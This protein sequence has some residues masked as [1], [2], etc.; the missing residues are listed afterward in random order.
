MRDITNRIINRIP[1]FYTRNDQ[2]VLIGLIE[3]IAPEL[4]RINTLVDAVSDMV[5]IDKV[6][7]QDLYERFGSLFNLS[8][9][10]YEDNDMYR[11]RIKAVV[12]SKYGGTKE[13]IQNTVATYVG[14]TNTE[15]IKKYIKIVGGWDYEGDDI[16]HNNII[17]NE[18]ND[19]NIGR[20][21]GYFIVSIDPKA[22]YGKTYVT[23]AK[24]VEIVNNVKAAGVCV[25]MNMVFTTERENAIISI[26]ED[27]IDKIIKNDGHDISILIGQALLNQYILHYQYDDM[28]L[29]DNDH[30]ALIGRDLLNTTLILN[31]FKL[32]PTYDIV[33]TN[34]VD[35]TIDSNLS[36]DDQNKC[37]IITKDEEVVDFNA[38][39]ID[40]N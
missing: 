8:R 40:N 32:N 16:F 4:E 6:R 31:K 7:N 10:A 34:N 33:D 15:D 14:L 37:T 5:S 35:N 25:F 30:D 1:S 36:I 9:Y 27:I 19:K 20:T 21:P 26:Q 11:G 22:L 39:D 17:G 24:I 18:D 38:I 3:S 28:T 23:T 29:R 13:L 2:S 12:A